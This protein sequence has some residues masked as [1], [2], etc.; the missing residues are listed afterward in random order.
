MTI[1]AFRS[2]SSGKGSLAVIYAFLFYFFGM[3][4]VHLPPD[5]LFSHASQGRQGSWDDT[6]R[7]VSLQARF[8]IRMS[9]GNSAS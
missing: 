3:A 5:P 9:Y 4:G 6:C 2:S 1:Q 8:L 7:P